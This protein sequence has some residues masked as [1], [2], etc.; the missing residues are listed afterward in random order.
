MT[1]RTAD[2]LSERFTRE[3][4]LA[5]DIAALVEPALEDLGFRLVR[6]QVLGRDGQTVQ[7]MAERMDGTMSID[8][9]ET[10][11]RQL[12]PL[13]DAHDPLPGSYRLEISS[14]G[15]DRPL[16]RPSDFSDWAGHEAKIALKNAIDGRKRYR[17][18]IEGLEGGKIRLSCDAEDGGPEPLTIAV[19]AIAE[20]KLVLTDDLVRDALRRAKKAQKA[21]VADE[22]RHSD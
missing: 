18:T 13:I 22:P 12:S 3:T 4:G 19:D 20:A 8:D 16:V 11:S 6:V 5:A 15:I 2:A 7:I 1:E 21:A 9:C 10:A 14:P 17:G